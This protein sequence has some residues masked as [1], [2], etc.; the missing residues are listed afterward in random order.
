MKTRALYAVL[1]LTLPFAGPALAQDGDGNQMMLIHQEKVALAHV[2]AYEAATRDMIALVQQN[3][4]TMPTFNFTASSSPEGN[5]TYV[6]PISSMA[7]IDTVTAEFE[8][9][10]AGPSGDKAREIFA[11]SNASLEHMSES[12]VVHHPALSY[13]PEEPRITPADWK[14]TMI[15]IYRIVPGKE[16]EAM[17]L[18]GEFKALW[19]EKKIA[20]AYSVFH[21]H[22]GPD[23]PALAVLSWGKDL[24]DLYAAA[25]RSRAQAGEKGAALFARAAALTRSYETFHTFQRPDLSLPPKPASD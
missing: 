15:E 13:T 5:Y 21:L 24:G 16:R 8:A 18:A 23:M 9:M 2:P 19:Q 10:M 22:M 14:V 11:R 25:D 17:A 3:R 7:D 20:E 1:C 6:M 12:V 4:D